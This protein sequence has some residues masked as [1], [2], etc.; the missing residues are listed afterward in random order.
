MEE[1]LRVREACSV[2]LYAALD[3]RSGTFCFLPGGN[4]DKDLVSV[5][6]CADG[7]L[8]NLGSTP[9]KHQGDVARRSVG[10]FEAEDGIASQPLVLLQSIGVANVD[11]RSDYYIF[12]GLSWL[13]MLLLLHGFIDIPQYLF[14]ISL[15][16]LVA[17]QVPSSI[18]S[19]KRIVFTGGSGK[20]GRHVIPYLLSKGHQVLN[21]DLVP[22]PDPSADV[23]TLKCDLTDSGQVFNALTTHFNMSGYANDS[24]AKPPDVVIHF[25]AYARF[26]FSFSYL[27]WSSNSSSNPLTAATASS[28]TTQPSQAT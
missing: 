8:S 19:G 6:F 28:P 16:L 26:V 20:A 17:S 27:L 9:R 15:L 7:L 1:A 13:L 22:F 25:G 21:L 23:Y 4:L 12:N 3:L 18:M 2:I 5:V 24:L 11:L 14:S 10:Q